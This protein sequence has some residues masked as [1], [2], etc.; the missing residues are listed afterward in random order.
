VR[1][2]GEV[3]TSVCVEY[4]VALRHKA[5]PQELTLLKNNGVDP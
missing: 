3:V 5:H 2:S 1:F 4:G